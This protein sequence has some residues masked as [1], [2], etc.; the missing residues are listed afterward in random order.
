MTEKLSLLKKPRTPPFFVGH[1]L[2]W[3][4]AFLTEVFLQ[5]LPDTLGEFVRAVDGIF[6]RL[7]DTRVLAA[8][9]ADELKV[10]DLSEIHSTLALGWEQEPRCYWEPSMGYRSGSAHDAGYDSTYLATSLF[11]GEGG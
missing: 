4:L 11:P 6:P 1:N 3:D 2:G 8:N 9:H 10:Y 7:L 5:P